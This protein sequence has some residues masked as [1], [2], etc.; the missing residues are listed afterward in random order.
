MYTTE[1]IQKIVT[2][3]S[4]QRMIQRVTNKYGESYVGLWLFQV[5]GESN[6]EMKALM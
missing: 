1:L 2:S 4:G 6:D 5:M 3:E